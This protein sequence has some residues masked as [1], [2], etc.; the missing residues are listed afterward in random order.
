MHYEGVN[1][2]EVCSRLVSEPDPHASKGLVPKLVVDIPLNTM[3][4]TPCTHV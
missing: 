4:I 2:P 3:H 1:L